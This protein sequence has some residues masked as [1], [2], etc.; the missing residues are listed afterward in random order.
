MK[1]TQVVVVG[2]G[3]VGAVAAYRLALAG[4][5]VV[6]LEAEAACPQDMRASTLHPPTL[7]MMSELGV[8]STLEDQGLRA[9]VYH[10]RNRRTN[11]VLAFDLGELADLT[12]YPYRLQCEQ[13]KVA[14]LLTGLLDALP[15]GA[16]RFSQR[17]L[18]LQ[19]TDDGVTVRVETPYEIVTYTADYVIA[20]DGANSLA[21][22]L[23]GISFD[24]FTYPE[25]FLTLSTS[26]PIE[27]SLRGLAYVNYVA[28]PEEWCVLLRVP[29]FWRVLVPA[30]KHEPDR[31]LL[32]DEKKTRVFER[33]VGAEAAEDLRTD[34][35]TIYRVHQ[36][37]A[38][39]YRGGR[40]LL[41]GDAAHLNNPLGGFGMNSGVH[42]V[43]NLTEKLIEILIDGAP[44][45]AALD[46]YD[47]Q[48]RTI[49][50]EFV[51][52]QTIRNKAM[53]ETSSADAQRANQRD[54]E[55]ILAD[56]ERRRDF[57][58][59]QAMLKSLERAK[60]IA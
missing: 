30:D 33:L 18:D 45:D 53:L 22:K 29:D 58:A 12:P 5:D 48:R 7:E 32:S 49:M 4:I 52:A 11:E 51:Q 35:R 27:E 42:D 31:A 1:R 59:T 26:W 8:L 44:A 56:D 23:L 55:A 43:W 36:R 47:R 39:T 15:N 40:V 54:M 13:F 46:L 21:R 10:Y 2:A 38:T 19:Q 9:P 28:D 3:P 60:A 57:L 34:H 50:H 37:V 16:M 24:G 17:V 41:A 6:L 20:A 14:R 25:K